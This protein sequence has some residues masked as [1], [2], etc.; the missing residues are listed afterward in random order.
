[1]SNTSE[2]ANKINKT[3][4]EDVNKLWKF[5]K[6]L[7]DRL[8]AF[9]DSNATSLILEKLSVEG[10]KEQ[11]FFRDLCRKLNLK[12]AIEDDKGLTLV[13]QKVR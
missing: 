4:R 3:S 7:E 1:M 13:K 11:Q 5:Q 8:N 12:V 9:L 10:V 6:D 2:W